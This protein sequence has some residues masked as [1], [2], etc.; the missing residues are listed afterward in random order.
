[1]KGNNELSVGLIVVALVILVVFVILN[2]SC[3]SEQQLSDEANFI[4]GEWVDKQCGD[5]I[6][7]I[8][9]K[10]VCSINLCGYFSTDVLVIVSCTKDEIINWGRYITER[11]TIA[12]VKEHD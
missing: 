12:Q 6:H 8:T 9:Y 11:C 3:F 1:M 7:N 2:S 5:G 4:D 10:L